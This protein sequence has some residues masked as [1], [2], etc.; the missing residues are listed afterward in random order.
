MPKSGYI[1]YCFGITDSSSGS[2]ILANMGSAVVVVI[3]D[4]IVVAVGRNRVVV[5]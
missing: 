5:G 2:C 3:V 4:H 1:V